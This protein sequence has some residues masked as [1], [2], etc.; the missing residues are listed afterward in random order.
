MSKV[1]VRVPATSANIGPG[2]DAAGLALGL[3]SDFTFEEIDKGLWFR[4]CNP[5]FDNAKNPIVQAYFATCDAIGVPHRGVSIQMEVKIPYASGLGASAVLLCAGAMAANAL[6]GSPL[7]RRQLLDL[8]CAIEGHPDNLA[9]AFFGGLSVSLMK[10][11]DRVYTGKFECAKDLRFVAM[12]PEYELP[13][14]VARKALPKSVPRKDAVFNL[15][16]AT[17]LFKALE[18]GDEELIR[19]AMDD[20]LHQPYRK[21]LIPCYDEVQS[22]CLEAGALGFCVSGAG[23]TL[24]ALTKDPDFADRIRPKIQALPHYWKVLNLVVDQEGARVYR[25]QSENP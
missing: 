25:E 6:H 8:T 5:G 22:L 16:H 18:T 20:R 2:F 24:L 10:E 15:S 19:A 14:S 7:S 12:I 9:P 21:Q 4:G 17:L 23:P 3:Y 11:N 1:T 13:T